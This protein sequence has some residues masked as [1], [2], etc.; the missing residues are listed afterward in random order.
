MPPVSAKAQ[1]RCLSLR[2]SIFHPIVARSTRDRRRSPVALRLLIGVTMSRSQRRSSNRMPYDLTLPCGCVAHVSA[3]PETGIV[4]LRVIQSRGTSCR[5]ARH[6]AGL[7][8]YLW[9][10]LPARKPQL[11]WHDLFTDLN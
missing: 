4:H 10:L 11:H 7:R 8:L 2:Q 1:A 3:H 6:Q 9:E 5:V